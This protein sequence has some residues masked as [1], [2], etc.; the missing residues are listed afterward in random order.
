MKDAR[1]CLSMHLHGSFIHPLAKARPKSGRDV[2]HASEDH[3]I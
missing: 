1:Y 3:P 2:G